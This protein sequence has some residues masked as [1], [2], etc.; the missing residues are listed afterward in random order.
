MKTKFDLQTIQQFHQAGLLDAAKEGYLAILEEDPENTDILL[1]LGV[2]CAQQGNYQASVNTFEAAIHYQPHDPVL[3]LNLGNALKALGLF[4]H[5]IQVFERAIQ[6]DHNY[7]AALN[8]LGTVYY[9]Q[10]HWDQAINYFLAAIAKKEDYLE[11]YYNLALAYSKR[12]QI[13]DAMHTYEKLIVMAP[14]YTAA[15]FQLGCLCLSHGNLK[16]AIHC[17]KAVEQTH[18]QQFETQSNLATC[19]LNLGLLS[20]AKLH[21]MKALQ[22]VPNDTQILFN[23]GVINMQQGHIDNAIDNYQ[24]ALHINPDFFAAHNNLGVAFLAK[25]KIGNALFHF[26]E[27]ARLQPENESIQFTINMLSQENPAA[28]SSVAYIKNLFDAYADHYEPHLINTL[29]YQIPDLLFQAI[30]TVKTLTPNSLDILDLGCGTGLCGLRFEPLAKSLTG[31]DLSSKMIAVAQQKDIYSELIVN[32]FL[33]GLENKKAGFDLIVAGDVLVYSGDLK[34]VFAAC[35]LALRDQGL[36]AFN[37]EITEKKDYQLNPSGRFTHQQK[38]LEALAI[39]S[40]FK[41]VYYQRVVTRQ[42]NNE[43]VYGHL[44]VLQS[45]IDTSP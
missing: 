27:A 12:N 34:P 45:M 39:E 42:Q 28:V 35:K 26:R 32:D 23:L 7:A 4:A 13:D 10:E 24:Q 5:A 11:A 22:L 1:A 44:Y 20:Q 18:P 40:G 15:Y 33:T 43:P 41:I 17:F 8:N 38:Y 2:L 25:Q 37:T 36:F 14:F 31:I 9:A 16:K 3:Y 30:N 21:Y 29:D 19:Y 6:L